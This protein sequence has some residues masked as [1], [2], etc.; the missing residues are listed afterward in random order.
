MVDGPPSQAAR[1]F[2]GRHD[3]S[4][5]C[6][7]FVA[8]SRPLPCPTLGVTVRLVA[9]NLSSPGEK[10][11]SENGCFPRCGA[12]RTGVLT[13]PPVTVTDRAH[14][15]PP[16]LIAPLVAGE[17]HAIGGRDVSI[18]LQ[19]NAQRTPVPLPGAGLKETEPAPFGRS[20]RRHRRPPRQATAV[21]RRSGSRIPSARSVVSRRTDHLTAVS[22]GSAGSRVNDAGRTG[23]RGSGRCPRG[24]PRRVRWSRRPAGPRGRRGP[25]AGAAAGPR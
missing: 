24:S 25:C 23:F 11:R 22:A 21:T 16:R 14:E 13:P 10:G 15:M 7:T 20:R 2:C 18:L 1:N 9:S 12:S 5:R 4:G 6:A 17:V 8:T 3:L 19:D